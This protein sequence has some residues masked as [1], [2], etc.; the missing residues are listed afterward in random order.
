M[1]PALVCSSS[2][3]RLS[4]ILSFLKKKKNEKEK[5][6][7]EWSFNYLLFVKIFKRNKTQTMSRLCS[8]HDWKIEIV[9][10]AGKIFFKDWKKKN[11]K[12]NFLLHLFIYLW[13]RRKK[14]ELCSLEWTKKPATI[15]RAMKLS[16]LVGPPISLIARLSIVLSWRP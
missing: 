14:V 4:H 2:L 9:K 15:L 10:K 3:V 5:S 11:K 13:D 12:F 16:E 7:Y 6:K 1:F 8:K